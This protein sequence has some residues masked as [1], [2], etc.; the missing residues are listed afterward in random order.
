MTSNMLG[1]VGDFGG[2]NARFALVENGRLT[3]E[4]L[5]TC[6]N[7]EYPT[8]TDAIRTFL[9]ERGDPKV[10][11]ACLALAGAITGDRFKFTNCAWEFSKQ[12]LTADIGLKQLVLTNDFTAL[13]MGVPMLVSSQ[14]YP[15]GG[16]KPQ[17]HKP[18]GVLGP[19]TGLGVSG[20]VWSGRHW[21][22][23]QGEGGHDGFAPTNE[24]E[25][26]ILRIGCKEYGGRL[27]SERILTGDGLEFLYRTLCQI[28]GK[29]AEKLKAPDI[30]KQAIE[31]HKSICYDVVSIFCGVLGSSA[32]DL[33]L[34]LGAFGGVFIGGGIMAKLGKELVTTSPLRTR[35]EAKG[36]FASYMSGIPTYIITESA[37]VA[38]VGA[39]AILTNQE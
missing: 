25:I 13:A 10:S 30:T 29:A 34:T 39:A 1:F 14:Y 21:V 17:A 24:L 2:T 35:F 36:R 16:G 38:L 18:I 9:K 3:Q 33:A 37:H 23:L 8:I 28:Q 26:E 6:V 22:A 27:S 12:E 5:Y 19:G 4:S 32:G 31:N 7:K 20:L 11:Y 15:L